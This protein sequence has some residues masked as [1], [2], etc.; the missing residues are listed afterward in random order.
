MKKTFLAEMSMIKRSTAMETSDVSFLKQGEEDTI[1]STLPDLDPTWEMVTTLF[2]GQTGMKILLAILAS[3]EIIQQT[4]PTWGLVDVAILNCRNLATF[5]QQL[6]CG[7]DTLL[8][9]IKVY[10]TLGLL[11]HSRTWRQQRSTT[12]LTLPLTPY[13]PSSEILERLNMLVSQGRKK[14]QELARFVRDRYILLYRLPQHSH[15]ETRVAEHPISGLLTRASYLLQKKRVRR[16]ERQ[17]LHDEITE[18]LAQMEVA[19]L[20]DPFFLWQEQGVHQE[21]RSAVEIGREEDQRRKKGDLLGTE[22]QQREDQRYEPE[23]PM[24]TA[25]DFS[26]LVVTKSGD[27]LQDVGD[28]HG[29]ASRRP[30][31]LTAYHGAFFAHTDIKIGDVGDR[32]QEAG[33]LIP[34]MGDFSAHPD[35]K[36]VLVGDLKDF[37]PAPSSID[38]VFRQNDSSQNEFELESSPEEPWGGS[39]EELSQ[40]AVRYLILL[41]GPEYATSE[42][43]NT[44]A[45]KKALGGYRNKIRRSPRLARLAAINTLLQRTFYDLTKQKK[46]L[47]NA[48]RWFHSSFDRYAD[49]GRPME[50]IGEIVNWAKSPYTLDEIA[51]VI[52]LERK[53]QETQWWSPEPLHRPFASCVTLH[54]HLPDTISE[55]QGNY[56]EENWG[57]AEA[58]LHREGPAGRS[59]IQ[60]VN[61]VEA[62][63]L[64]DEIRYEA[65]WYLENIHVHPEPHL[66][67]NAYVVEASIVDTL[68]PVAYRTRQDWVQDHQHQVR[69]R[70]RE[71]QRGEIYAAHPS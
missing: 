14:Q 4:L 3:A 43:L 50:I 67:E 9:Y 56:P 21:D 47:E 11:T 71:Q 62:E 69:H 70:M 54:H 64:A 19:Q 8:R 61:C 7:K 36:T 28:L 33:D 16:I 58:H 42:Y 18:V 51:L 65:S 25:G 20:G 46:P 41:D 52:P 35:T 12:E 1:S 22:R 53:R 13:H 48:G 66:G 49:P 38:S 29:E 30:G 55:A 2:P 26:S 40:E 32:L 68:F 24:V 57:E 5:A 27:Q 6:G 60:G 44:H 37:S 15:W 45:G 17:V 59:A 39:E 10:Q 34:P 63:Q 23:D 31:D